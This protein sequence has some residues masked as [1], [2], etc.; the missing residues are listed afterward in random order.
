MLPS[1]ALFDQPINQSIGYVHWELPVGQLA[2]YH[3][4]ISKCQTTDYFIGDLN[5]TISSHVCCDKPG[6][7]LTPPQGISDCISGDKTGI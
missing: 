1:V 2:T 6:V 3:K 5:W 4:D 7:F